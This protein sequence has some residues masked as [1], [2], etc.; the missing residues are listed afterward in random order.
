M[1]LR[2]IDSW[3][4]YFQYFFEIYNPFGY[5]RFLVDDERD[6]AEKAEHTAAATITIGLPFHAYT[7]MSTGGYWANLPPGSFYRAA[8]MKKFQGQLVTNFVRSISPVAARVLTSSATLPLVILFAAM[9]VGVAVRPGE[10]ETETDRVN[11]AINTIRGYDD[12]SW[13]VDYGHF[14]ELPYIENPSGD[15]V[16]YSFN[17]QDIDGSHR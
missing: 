6:W 13:M 15:R 3:S 10:L 7:A 11:R 16:W 2:E 8:S 1:R 4:D 14:S 12:T 17:P 5:L 9:Y